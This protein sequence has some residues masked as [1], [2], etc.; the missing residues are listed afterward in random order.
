MEPDQRLWGSLVPGPHPVG[1]ARSWQLDYARQYASPYRDDRAELVADRGFPRPILVSL[2]YPARASGAMPLR[3][4]D[5]LDIGSDD[6]L[7]AP[8][9]KRLEAFTRRTIAEEVLEERPAKIDATEAAGIQA[10]LDAATYAVKD[11]PVARGR[12]PLIV[13]HL[14]LGGTFEDNAVFYEYMA[15]H[16]YVVIVAPY[17]SEN[18]AYLNIDWDLDRSVKDMDFLVRYAKS[19]PGFDL[20]A[21]GAIGHSYGAQAVLAWRAENNSPLD[22]VVSLDST[23]DHC[24][25][26]E[27]GFAPLRARLASASRLA[28]PIFIYGSQEQKPDFVAHWSYLKYTRLY[29]AAVPDVEHNDF[30]TQ[31]AARFAFLPGRRVPADKA[32]AIRKAYDQVCRFTRAFFDAH[33]KGDAKAEANL[34][35]AAQGKVT[36]G[37]VFALTLREPARL[38]PSAGQLRELALRDG[39]DAAISLA[40][41]FGTDITEDSLSDAADE[42]A[43]EDKSP[44]AVALATLRCELFPSSWVGKK[45]LGDLLLNADDR[46]GALKAY[47]EAEKLIAAGAKPTPSER[48]RKWLAESLKKAVGN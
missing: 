34:K 46:A 36:E 18:S 45:R 42:L 31:G 27:P 40:K 20:G 17:Q 16:G 24:P 44:W 8:F 32:R 5:Y 1:F 37:A 10:W 19:R 25:V 33:L 39:I 6:P 3:Y 4:R 26:D 14:G 41:R 47:R 11:A 7:I 12:F 9:A 43:R 28:G 35:R 30:V 29:T 22:A 15:S 21:I 38:P 23:V 48:A 13:A 2:W